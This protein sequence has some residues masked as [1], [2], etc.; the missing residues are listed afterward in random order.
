MLIKLYPDMNAW[1]ANSRAVRRVTPDASLNTC[2]NHTKDILSYL[3][4]NIY[5]FTFGAYSAV[6]AAVL[7]S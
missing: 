4:N 1:G 3:Y 7:R 2:V 6:D 5:K